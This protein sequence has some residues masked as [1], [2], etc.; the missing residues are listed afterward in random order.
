MATRSRSTDQLLQG[1]DAW[2][3]VAARVWDAQ[4]G[5][6]QESFERLM[7]L[8]E[9]LPGAPGVD[10]PALVTLGRGYADFVN[11]AVGLSVGYAEDLATLAR[12]TAADLLSTE[13][14]SGPRSA[15]T[16]TI[17]VR[18]RGAVG[19]AVTTRITLAN[20][21]PDRHTV[22]FELGPVTGPHG[23]FAPDL[24]VDPSVL[25]LTPDEEAS[26]QLT[27]D[28][29]PEHYEPGG[30][31]SCAVTVHGGDAAILAL[32]IEVDDEPA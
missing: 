21:Q 5:L 22:T 15:H 11:R 6:A 17:P 31:Y 19:A 25:S 13:T 32:S 4:V 20:H 26:V 7:S 29:P 8:A 28:L 27:L 30:T 16:R 12:E 3:R 23:T 9:S 18:L 14:R 1:V 2:E 24:R 10:G